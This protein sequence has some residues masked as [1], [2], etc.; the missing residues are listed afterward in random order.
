[1][2]KHDNIVEETL[3]F[4]ER[5]KITGYYGYLDSILDMTV[6]EMTELI[7]EKAKK[8]YK[9]IHLVLNLMAMKAERLEKSIQITSSA[10]IYEYLKY[11]IVP[12]TLFYEEFWVIYLNRN[13]RIITTEKISQGGYHGTVA[14]PKMIIG[15]GLQLK[16]S[17]MIACHNHP[18]GSTR[19]SNA[20]IQLTKKIKNAGDLV[21]ILLLDHIIVTNKSYY[22]FK[23]E[24][25]I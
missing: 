16:A 7:G 22:S 18:S 24:G 12:V 15:K 4:Y 1:M 10:D 3:T 21:D 5:E 25:V 13:N 23:D 11:K 20:D 8:L 19:P 6:D 17:T 2:E 14:D 9:S